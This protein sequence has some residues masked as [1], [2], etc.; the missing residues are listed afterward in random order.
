MGEFTKEEVVNHGFLRRDEEI[1]VDVPMN[2]DVI[3]TRNVR[4]DNIRADS[5]QFDES[6]LNKVLRDNEGNYYRIV[7]Q[8]YEFLKKHNL[9]LPLVH[10]FTRLKMHFRP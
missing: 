9:P 3:E 4:P 5:D 8:E 2:A 6:I 1:K 10:W 7:K